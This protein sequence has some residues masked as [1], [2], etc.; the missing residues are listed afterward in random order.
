VSTKISGVLALIPLLA[1]HFYHKK[2]KGLLSPNLYLMLIVSGFAFIATT[3]YLI[4][5]FR[6]VI[7]DILYEGR[8]YSTGHS[9]MEGNSLVW[10]LNY[11]WQTAGVIYLIAAL[12]ILRGVY[13]RSKEII[14]LSI[15]PI[16]YFLFVSSFVVRNDRTLLPLT[17]FLFLLA[18]SFLVSL[19]NRART[20]QSKM[21][22]KASI[23]AIASLL[24]IGLIM[25]I[26]ETITNTIRLTTVDSRETARIW[27]ND[28]L[29]AGARIAIESYSPFVEPTRFSVQ[30]FGAMLDH[31][32]EWF[33]GQGF[34]YLVFSQGMYKRFYHEPERYGL[35][36]SQ[37]DNLFKQFHLLRLFTDGGYEVRIYK[38]K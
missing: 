30:S 1:A 12:E 15:F 7:N 26:S 36:I 24:A 18:A 33:I 21:S 11:M 38:V 22:K 32:P 4:G 3:P 35:E 25:P 9:G 5:D 10:Y 19:W 13:S 37:Y 20:L 27:I 8:H 6:D 28:N 14:G 31:D 23:L 16:V 29:P 2:L 17:P 34:D